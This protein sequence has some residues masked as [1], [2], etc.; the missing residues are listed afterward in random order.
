MSTPSS[1]FIRKGLEKLREIFGRPAPQLEGLEVFDLGERAVVADR[2]AAYY[3]RLRKGARLLDEAPQS[4]DPY[5]LDES[6]P[7]SKLR[8]VERNPR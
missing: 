5:Q 4:W 7:V 3:D 1:R 8:L 6:K 2:I